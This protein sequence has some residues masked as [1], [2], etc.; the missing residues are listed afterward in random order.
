[1]THKAMASGGVLLPVLVAERLPKSR[2]CRLWCPHCR[3]WHFHG[4]EDG[5]RAAHCHVPDSPY[6]LDG[7]YV[8]ISEHGLARPPAVRRSPGRSRST[9]D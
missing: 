4:A 8:V 3:A 5:P 7:Y 9:R 1:M 6:H 2:D